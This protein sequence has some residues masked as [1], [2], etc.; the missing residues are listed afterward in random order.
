[1]ETLFRHAVPPA[2]IFATALEPRL[3]AGCRA[4]LWLPGRVFGQNDDDPRLWL[5][6]AD[7]RVLAFRLPEV[8]LGED[9]VLAPIIDT[10][11]RDV[12]G[13]RWAVEHPAFGAAQVLY[14]APVLPL[15]DTR[16]AGFCFE[17]DF[18]RFAASLDAEVMRL[19]LSLEREPHPP[20]LTRRDGQ[21]PHPLP[22]RFF[23]SVRNYNR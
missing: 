14:A 3:P 15:A 9:A 17:A 18:Q 19:L 5:A 20:A 21:G 22:R 12:R 23:A 6:L 2:P 10:L 8:E 4:R 7:G 11:A 1:M 16:H 13:N